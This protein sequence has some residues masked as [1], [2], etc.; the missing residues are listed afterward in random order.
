MQVVEITKKVA[1][2]TI[3]D[4][5]QSEIEN[6]WGPV[7][8]EIEA[9]SL[10]EASMRSSLTN[11]LLSVWSTNRNFF[12]SYVEPT[13]SDCLRI[14]RG[15]YDAETLAIINK[16]GGTDIYLPLAAQ[17]ANTVE[18]WLI[19]LLASNPK[20]K[21]WS[22]EPTP[23]PDIPETLKET[24][25]QKI[26]QEGK[27]AEAQG[28]KPTEEQIEKR[29][30]EIYQSAYEELER[31]AYDGTKLQERNISD[32]LEESNF[33]GELKRLIS[34]ICVFPVGFIIG[35]VFRKGFKNAWI[36]GE[37]EQTA[38]YKE[39]YI[40][41]SPFDVF[42]PPD[43]NDLN[44]GDVVW[45]SKMT[46]R[47]LSELKGT[48][49]SNDKAIQK[50]L[51]NFESYTN[52]TET[53]ETT[54]NLAE[55]KDPYHNNSSYAQALNF[56]ASVPIQVLKNSLPPEATDC[57]N[58][59]IVEI[60]AT[61]IG[62]HLIKCNIV[63]TD[64]PYFSRPIH[65]TSFR[66]VPDS[67]YG[68]SPIQLVKEID[69]ICN[70][71]IR[72]MV[73]N[74][75]ISSGPQ[76]AV[77]VNSIPQTDEAES[78]YPW[79]I[80]WLNNQV[81]SSNQLPIHFFQP[82]SNAKELLGVFDTMLHRAVFVTGIPEFM[83]GS[84]G[85]T[86]TAAGTARGL[87]AI[88]DSSAKGLKLCLSNISEDI[89]KPIVYSQF[90]VNILKKN[91]PN[92]YG[93]VKVIASG[94]SALVAQGA[95][96]TTALELLKASQDPQIRMILGEDGILELLKVIS[97]S[98]GLDIETLPT[99]SE[100]QEKLQKA[101]EE[102]KSKPSEEELK[103]Q[104]DQAKIEAD[105]KKNNDRQMTADKRLE[106][107]KY[108]L[109]LEAQLKREEMATNLKIAELKAQGTLEASISSGLIKTKQQKLE[110][111]FKKYESPDKKGI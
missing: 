39:T 44:D 48:K 61:I 68:M 72:S 33:T 66:K 50:V 35:P 93:D 57:I 96:E 84:S 105:L 28:I 111:D 86:H 102:A 90:M 59:D 100:L 49:G 101:A 54:R 31:I 60:E 15:R 78:L 1:S 109:E 4:Y 12:N 63:D 23:I 76:V 2:D 25:N 83:L 32:I 75:S 3:P 79:K 30:N 53:N 70:S 74:L 19:D 94:I 40:A 10:A 69:E 77:D 82:P 97:H 73:N 26:L 5:E 80:W 27:E 65:A 58:K 55:I 81:A 108:K 9:I 8:D 110:Q 56:F 34:Y 21:P 71:C 107:E 89:I 38:D 88:L 18:S 42:P 106:F 98:S 29:A 85:K 103:H 95:R 62:D 92:I 36:N 13:L 45:R 99:P 104:I 20:A 11:H 37:L 6:K 22:L 64:I 87:A 7:V 24:L 17:I 67:L 43:A 14:S 91:A 51:D 16:I 52:W 46:R 47:D 41:V